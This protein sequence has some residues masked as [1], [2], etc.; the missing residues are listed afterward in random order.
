MK[1][2]AWTA[3]AFTQPWTTAFP[4]AA[5]FAVWMGEVSHLPS[6]HRHVAATFVVDLIH[7]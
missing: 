2:L 7:R 3:F 4:M 6:H 1:G 5:F